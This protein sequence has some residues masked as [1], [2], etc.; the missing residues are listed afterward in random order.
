MAGKERYRAQTVAAALLQSRGLVSY[1]AQMLGC[2]QMTVRRSMARRASVR[3]PA[4]WHRQNRY[5]TT[6]ADATGAADE[7]CVTQV[8]LVTSWVS[9][10][11]VTS[12]VTTID[13]ERQNG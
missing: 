6:S 9:A 4:G 10:S 8:P 13:G 3:G 1:A 11:E 2:A 12:R 7:R 5:A